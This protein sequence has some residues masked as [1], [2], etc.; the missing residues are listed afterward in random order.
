MHGE[1]FGVKAS[2]YDPRTTTMS[3]LFLVCF[4][5]FVDIDLKKFGISSD[6]PTPVSTTL[7]FKKNKILGFYKFF[8]FEKLRNC[9]VELKKGK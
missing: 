8:G 7:Y 2:I 3:S 5:S 1:I 6:K 9:I 4:N